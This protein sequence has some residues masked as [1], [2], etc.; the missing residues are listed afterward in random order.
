MQGLSF[1]Q[2]WR[3]ACECDVLLSENEGRLLYRLVREA[4]ENVLEV[5]SRHGGSAVLMALAGAHKL[6]LI[7]PLAR[8]QL[9]LSL[10]RFDLLQR[11]HVLNYHDTL[12]WPIWTSELSF[13]FLD[14]E[15][16]YLDVRNSL[17]GWRGHLRRGARIAIH[18]YVVFEEVKRGVD[19]LGPALKIV[20][21][22][23]SMVV[24]TWSDDPSLRTRR[25]SRS[26]T[27]PGKSR[28]SA[29]S[30]LARS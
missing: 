25:K 21:R 29:R 3:N 2:A 19:D 4:P 20:D 6:T 9:L 5:G 11:V 24:A 1:E 18:D 7:E 13:L 16:E 26:M 17:V 22:I 8:P 14:H 27:L 28:R 23:D 10:A 30:S 15:H 12:V